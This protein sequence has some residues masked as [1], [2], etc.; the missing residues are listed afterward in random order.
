[1]NVGNF[2]QNTHYCK[3]KGVKVG[4]NIS[5]SNINLDGCDYDLKFVAG[6]EYLI[7]TIRFE[8]ELFVSVD[9][10][11]SKAVEDAGKDLKNVVKI[12]RN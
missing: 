10:G 6:K 7:Y 12:V 4:R 3:W 8:K 11:G 5:L 1:M 9:C 2:Y